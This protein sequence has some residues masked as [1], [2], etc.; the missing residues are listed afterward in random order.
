[1]THRDLAQSKAFDLIWTCAPVDL[2][3]EALPEACDN[4]GLGERTLLDNGAHSSD[5]LFP[6]LSN[7]KEKQ[8][9]IDARRKI[10][11]PRVLGLL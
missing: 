5:D 2:S 3:H 8:E 10:G 6:V 4:F 7:P 1:M 11:G 9:N